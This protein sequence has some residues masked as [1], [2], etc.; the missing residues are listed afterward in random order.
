MTLVIQIDD[1][2][3]ATFAIALSFWFPRLKN[4]STDRDGKSSMDSYRQKYWS[5][6]KKKITI[7]QICIAHNI[8]KGELSN[9]NLKFESD[10][11]FSTYFS[12]LETDV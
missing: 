11:C 10:V 9:C 8:L 5:Y 4:T 3:G 1:C 2:V 7:V 12:I 6:G